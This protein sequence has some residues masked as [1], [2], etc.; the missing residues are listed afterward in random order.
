L[1]E[2]GATYHTPLAALGAGV[3]IGEADRRALPRVP[4][5]QIVCVF[6]FALTQ[7]AIPSGMIATF[8]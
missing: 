3:V 6:F 5:D 7:P 8:V 4:L 2:G 1:L